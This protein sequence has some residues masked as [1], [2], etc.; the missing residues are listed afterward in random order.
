MLV[1]FTLHISVFLLFPEINS[2]RFRRLNSID[3]LPHDSVYGITQDS[4]GFI[5]IGTQDGLA[6]YDGHKFTIYKHNP[7]NE[8][9]LS[10]SNFGKVVEGEDGVLWIGTWGGGLNRFNYRTGKFT[11]FPNEHKNPGKYIIAMLKDHKGYIWLCKSGNGLERFDPRTETFIHYRHDPNNPNSLSSDRV[12]IICEDRQGMIWIGTYEGGLNR[13]NPETGVF[14]HYRHDPGN[15]NSLSNDLVEAL[16]VDSRDNL[17]V[18]T[19]GGGLNRLAL[20]SDRFT[21]FPHIPGDPNS[22]SDNAVN[23]LLEDRSGKIWIGNYSK[24]LDCYD[25]KTGEFDHFHSDSKDISSISKDRIEVLYEDRSGVLWIGTKGGGVS[26]LD[27]KDEKFDFYEDRSLL[28]QNLSFNV[29]AIHLDQ[30]ADLWVGTDGGGLLRIRQKGNSIQSDI[31]TPDPK[32]YNKLGYS[33]IWS[34]FEDSQANF[35]IGTFSGLFM[36]DKKKLTFTKIELDIP[37]GN[38]LNAGIVNAIYEDGHG[39]LWISSQNGLFKIRK[40]KDQIHSKFYKIDKEKLT[41]NVRDFI[42]CVYEDSEKNLWVGSEFGLF[43]MDRDSGKTKAFIHDKHNASSLSYDKINTIF[44]DSKNRLWIGSVVGLN[45]LDRQTGQFKRY[46]K[47]D[48][49]ANNNIKSIVED[50]HGHLWMSTSNGLSRFDPVRKAFKRYHSTNGNISYNFNPRALVKDRNGKIM[51]GSTNGI[52]SFYPE[53]VIDNRFIPPIIIS[54]L[55]SLKRDYTEEAYI[56]GG[57]PLKLPYTDNTIT[58]EFSGLEFTDPRQNQYAYMLENFDTNWIQCGTRHFGSYSNIPPGRYTLRI[59]GSNNDNVWNREGASL[60]IVV[61]PPFWQTPLFLIFAAFFFAIMLYA[62][63]KFRMMKVQRQKRNLELIVMKRTKELKEKTDELEKIN[64]NL[65]DAQQHAQLERL[66]AEAANKSKSEFLARMSHEIRTPMNS[67]IGFT[68]MLLNTK[69]DEEQEDFAHT[70]ERSGESLLGIINDILDFS[71]IEAGKL[72]FESIDFD[73][74]KAIYEVCEQAQPRIANKP[75]ELLCKIGSGLPAYVKG[76]PGR[77]RQ[78]L[79][80]L[81]GNAIKFTEKGEVEISC[82][83][84]EEKKDKLKFHISVKD[85]GIGIHQDKID[86]IFGVFQQSDGSITRKFGGTGL[87]LPICKQISQLM[88]GD[89]YARSKFGIGSIFHFTCWLDKSQKSGEKIDNLA[90]LKDK[91]V[92][93]VDDNLSNLKILNHILINTGMKVTELSN[94][95]DVLPTLIDEYEAGHVFDLCIL[96]IEMPTIGG[97]EI[98]KKI[99]NAKKAFSNIL[100]LAYSSN[101]MQHIKEYKALGFSS[102]LPKPV[103]KHKLLNTICELMGDKKIRIRKKLVKNGSEINDQPDISLGID[104]IR[105]L[106]AEDNPINQKLARHMLS[107]AGYSVYIA[108]N[109]K[110]AVEKF[111]MDPDKFDIILMD[112]QMPEIDG[113][114]ATI[115]IRE[116]EKMQKPENKSPIPIIAMTAESM[117]GDR[118]RCIKAGMNDYISKPIKQE[119]VFKILKKYIF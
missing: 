103:T 50:R 61:I 35:W 23:C 30:Q 91:R 95:S 13:L 113:L 33:R 7:M 5:W 81:L 37:E 69:L 53:K 104:S 60:E 94:G 27:L 68:E 119:T 8:N 108:N 73:P 96:D 79:V 85:T 41:K 65:V 21:H 75:I 80:N 89:I 67:I 52:I 77:F 86:S 34:L 28:D 116:L 66:A 29:Y 112:I 105:I 32:K 74:E 59:I 26:V 62:F 84:I 107:R 88:G 24:G 38:K 25:P 6:K 40:D 110:E 99:R 100:L 10:D 1:G 115:Q 97:I 47:S 46:F 109:G 12:R 55:K 71:K 82:D 111:K 76:D 56:Y 20:K 17:W 45:Q 48:G 70:I 63:I 72:N 14:K 3:G 44:E 42:T 118:D 83:V 57:K 43:L 102:Y 4:I 106:L 64:K 87:G 9:S 117:K 98:A 39:N 51:F 49:L 36:F 58:F 22:I 114:Q 31:F 15:P 19:R 101:F 18:G 11:H 16:C 93:I 54:S 78:V 90:K 2:K 92:L